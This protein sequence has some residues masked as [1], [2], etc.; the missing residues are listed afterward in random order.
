[1]THEDRIKALDALIDIAVSEGRCNWDGYYGDVN[2][3]HM[4]FIKE[5]PEY[6]AMVDE[7][8]AALTIQNPVYH[9]CEAAG[10]ACRRNTS[11]PTRLCHTHRRTK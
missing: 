1:M 9:R 5:M 6:K 2:T 11:H 10:R 8:G 4:D 3:F 7:L